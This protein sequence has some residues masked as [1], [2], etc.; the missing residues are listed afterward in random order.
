MVAQLKKKYVLLCNF[1][2]FFFLG[3]KVG[4]SSGWWYMVE[5]STLK[6]M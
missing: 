3:G 5:V 2:Q 1:G 4:G 6:Y